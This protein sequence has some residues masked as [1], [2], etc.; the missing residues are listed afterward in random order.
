M[1][2]HDAYPNRVRVADNVTLHVLTWGLDH[3][4]TP[5][6][7]VHELPSNPRLWNGVA[8]RLAAAGHPVA[9]IDQRGH[10][11]SDKPD[12]RYDF[13]TLTDDLIAVLHDLG[14][15]T[16]WLAG[17][18]WGANVVLELAARHPGSTAGLVLVDG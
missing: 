8:E 18:S 2:E 4:G 1:I 11:Q 16:P 13:A 3:P 15:Q 12:D 7:L 17:Q 10:G 6:L 14:G 5:V 9:A